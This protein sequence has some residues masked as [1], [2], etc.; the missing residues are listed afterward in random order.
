MASLWAG[1]FAWFAMAFS[2]LASGLLLLAIFPPPLN[3]GAFAVLLQVLEDA[4]LA[5]GTHAVLWV[6]VAT[7]LYYVERV[8][9][10]GAAPGGSGPS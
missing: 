10:R 8:V 4:R 1:L 6:A 2:S 7:L 9:L 3:D 5:L